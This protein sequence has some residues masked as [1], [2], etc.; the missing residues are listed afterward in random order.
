MLLRCE[1]LEPPMSQLGQPRRRPPMQSVHAL[2]QFPRKPTSIQ[3]IG[4]RRT[5]ATA[6][7]PTNFMSFFGIRCCR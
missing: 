2:P 5:G 7:I 6:D 3:G 1:S 4:L